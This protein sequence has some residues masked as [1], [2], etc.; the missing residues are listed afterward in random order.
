MYIRNNKGITLISLIITL[1][2]ILILVSVGTYNTLD[3]YKNAKK[4]EFIYKMQLIQAKVDSND[5]DKD[6]LP[7]DTIDSSSNEYIVIKNV[8]SE[9]KLEGINVNEWKY[10]SNEMLQSVFGLENLEDDIAINFS[11]REIISIQ[12]IEYNEKI[13]HTQYQLPGGQQL[14]YKNVNNKTL[15]FNIET[16]IDG[17]NANI[18]ISNIKLGAEEIKVCKIKYKLLNNT[19]NL[20]NINED[21]KLQTCNN[22]NADT[23]HEIDGKSFS[24]VQTGKYVILVEYDNKNCL[25]QEEIVLTNTPKLKNIMSKCD[26]DGTAIVEWDSSYKYTLNSNDAFSNA[27]LVNKG[28]QIYMWVPRFAY[29]IETD[30][31]DNEIYSIK[32]LKGNSNIPTDNTIIDNKWNI[33]EQ[34]SII[35]NEEEIKYT[36]IWINITEYTEIL[37]LQN[38]IELMK[39]E[40]ADIIRVK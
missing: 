21:E 17:L 3:S 38:V 5:Y 34:F 32:Y 30:K 23:W 31:D 22:D 12:G 1:V 15:S 11:T 33:P 27:P 28:T 9:E 10:F 19:I 4:D 26:K 37:N 35:K 20:E 6:M 2:I 40:H 14:K 39:N 7:E 8:I 18:T 13:Y 16:K 29:K 24:I 36:G 25:K